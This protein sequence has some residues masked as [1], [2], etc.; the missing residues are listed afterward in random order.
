MDENQLTW[1]TLGMRSRLHE[2]TREFLHS[3]LVSVSRSK[4]LASSV[5]LIPPKYLLDTPDQRMSRF[6]CCRKNVTE[7][8]GEFSQ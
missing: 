6:G 3:P 7:W 4:K 5:L 8:V 1:S 2:S